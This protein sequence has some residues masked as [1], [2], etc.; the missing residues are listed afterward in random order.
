MSEEDLHKSKRGIVNEPRNVA[1]YLIRQLR[2]DGLGEICKE[3]QM[4]RY[5]SA[6]RVM[7]RVTTQISQDRRLR[8]RVEALRLI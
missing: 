6:H 2:E 3:F 8:K 7:E 5:S 4:K 1:A